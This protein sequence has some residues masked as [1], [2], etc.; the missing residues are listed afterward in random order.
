MER[1]RVILKEREKATKI[2][3][4]TAMSFFVIIFAEPNS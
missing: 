3:R 4:M 2:F 1:I